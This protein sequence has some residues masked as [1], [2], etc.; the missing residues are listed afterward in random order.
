MDA[1]YLFAKYFA[2]LKYETLPQRVVEV[3]KQQ[4]LDFFGVALPG[5][6]KAGVTQI[7][8]LTVEWGGAPQ[9]SIIYWGQK[10]PAPNAAQVN[11][12]MV[13]A[14]DFDD[15]HEAAVMHPGVVTIPPAL[16][17]AEMKGGLTGKE[18]I[19]AIALGTDFICRLGLATRPD[20]NIISTGWHL[21]SLYGFMCSAAVSGR[22]LGLSEDEIINAIGIAYHQ[23]AGNGQCTKDGALT[24]RMGPGFAV[25][26]GVSS[27]LMAEKG[28]TGAKNSLEGP[29]GMF[30]VYHQGSYSQS[31]LIGEL[32]TR[33]ESVRVSIKPYPCCRGVHPFIDASLELVNE[34]HIAAEEVKSITAY[35]GK[36]TYDLLCSP[37]EAKKRPRNV[38]DGQF[39]VPWGVAAAIARKR[40]AVDDFTEMAIQSQDILDVSS[41]IE[42]EIDASLSRSN[43]IEPARVNIVTKGGEAFTLQVDHPTGTP[44]KPMSFADCERKFRDCIANAERRL[45]DANADSLVKLASGLEEVSDVRELVDLVIWD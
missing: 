1:A 28:V 3:T 18:F 10:V 35:C 45:P 19:T 40:V 13:H 23:S 41:K 30:N 29:F 21:T 43:D 7:K 32:G 2:N 12:T 20:Q 37:L 44:E 11:A 42:I 16:A 14:L 15:V 17:L 36:G 33:F 39:S 34:H 8:E 24:K 5:S 4:V 25:K 9:S 38:V 26:G 22:I 27:A 31:Q 6:A